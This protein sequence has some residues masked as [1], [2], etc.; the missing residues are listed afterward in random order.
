MRRARRVNQMVVEGGFLA[1]TA[2][3]PTTTRCDSDRSLSQSPRPSRN[4]VDRNLIWKTVFA[5]VTSIALLLESG[6]SPAYAIDPAFSSVVSSRFALYVEETGQSPTYDS[7]YASEVAHDAMEILTSVDKELAPILAGRPVSRIIVRFLSEDSFYRQT[8]APTW[9]SALFSRGEIRIPVS[10]RDRL[11]PD[12]LRRTLRHEYIHAVIAQVSDFH[13]PAWL[14]EGLAQLIEGRYNPKLVPALRTLIRTQDAFPLHQLERGFTELDAAD[15][16]AAYAQSLFAAQLLLEHFGLPRVLNY[17][18]EL[19]QGLSWKRSFE[20]IFRVSIA[21]FEA[22]L[23]EAIRQWAASGS[24]ELIWTA[25]PMSAHTR[26]KGVPLEA[27]EANTIR[28]R[29]R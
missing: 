3:S 15:V 21:E 5:F 26:S 2:V 29:M 9:T 4:L 12:E 8:S 7:K 24:T 16:P 1:L 6:A 18:D 14:D 17:L 19:Q 27:P 11:H 23:N 22:E 13:C 28:A 25:P 20:R 10:S